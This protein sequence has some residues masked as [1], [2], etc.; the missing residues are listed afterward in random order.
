MNGIQATQGENQVCAVERIPRLLEMGRTNRICVS[1]EPLLGE[2]K[3]RVQLL[4][5]TKVR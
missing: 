1:A 3:C 2:I 5:V 4:I